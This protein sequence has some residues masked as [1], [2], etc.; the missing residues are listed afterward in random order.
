[1]T[2]TNKNMPLD[3]IERSR[4]PSVE[5][6]FA[7]SHPS[8]GI[9]LPLNPS[10]LPLPHR[11][12]MGR[13]TG[14]G[15]PVGQVLST[16]AARDP[17]SGRYAPSVEHRFAGSH[18]S[19]G[20]SLPLNPSSLPLPHRGKMGRPTGF[21]PATP[22]STILCSNQLS[23]GRRKEPRKFVT[24]IQA[25]NPFFGASDAWGRLL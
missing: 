23:Y 18:P 1:M 3:S 22:R 21:E 7:G 16:R 8:F 4:C 10:S 15:W 9:S 12:E 13:P 14:L 17:I 11:G 20:I 2:A 25:V 24:S 19:F 5:H 6:R